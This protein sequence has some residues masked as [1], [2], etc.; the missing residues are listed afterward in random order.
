MKFPFRTRVHAC[1]HPETYKYFLLADDAL[2]TWKRCAAWLDRPIAQN[3]ALPLMEI[4]A[5]ELLLRGP[6]TGTPIT[7][8]RKRRCQPS[9]VRELHLLFGFEETPNER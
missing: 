8:I 7:V 6:T 4:E 1:I 3:P 5:E 2:D 9:T